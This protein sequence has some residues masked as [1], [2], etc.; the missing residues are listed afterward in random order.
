VGRGGVQDHLL[1]RVGIAIL[2][3]SR[4]D[5]AECP[6]GADFLDRDP[7]SA[8]ACPHTLRPAGTGGSRGSLE[9]GQQRI[10]KR[11]RGFVFTEAKD[12]FG[13]R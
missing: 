13:F 3:K 10:E 5:H 6:T 11:P 9:R 12:R 8:P 7:Q 2:E 4:G 1:L